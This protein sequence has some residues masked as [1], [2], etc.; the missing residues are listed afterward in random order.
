MVTHSRCTA[1]TKLSFVLGGFADDPQRVLA[2]VEKPVVSIKRSLNLCVGVGISDLGGLELGLA[3]FTDTYGR[4]VPCTFRR[5][6]FA[7]TAV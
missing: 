3:A 2:A 7:I 4:S 6:R 5:L 1:I